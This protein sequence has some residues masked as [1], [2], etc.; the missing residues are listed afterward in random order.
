MELREH[1][2]RREERADDERERHDPR[3][4]YS[5]RCHAISCVDDATAATGVV[6]HPRSSLDQRD[7]VVR[8]TRHTR[9]TREGC[10]K[11]ERVS[12]VVLVVVGFLYLGWIYPLFQSLW[13]TS[14][15]QK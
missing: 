12:Q 15:L 6:C 7:V 2:L 1:R 9:H 11:R 8:H 10:M 14:W 13:W 3:D 5:V 4:P